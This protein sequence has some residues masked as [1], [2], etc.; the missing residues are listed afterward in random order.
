MD[1]CS[2]IIATSDTVK[3]DISRCPRMQRQKKPSESRN[4]NGV[5]KN[6]V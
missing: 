6:L 4:A 1:I 2:N 5:K 3:D